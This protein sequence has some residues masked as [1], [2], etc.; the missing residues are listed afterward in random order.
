MGYG[1][2]GG[3]T[4]LGTLNWVHGNSGGDKAYSIYLKVFIAQ[5]WSVSIYFSCPG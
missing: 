4:K 1:I 5:F 2:G 3:D